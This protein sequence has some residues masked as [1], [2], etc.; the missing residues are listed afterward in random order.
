M[1]PFN[2]KE[3]KTFS[4]GGSRSSFSAHFVLLS[5][6]LNHFRDRCGA[7]NLDIVGQVTQ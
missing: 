2:A 3:S 6:M 1:T 4:S 5:Y 7:S